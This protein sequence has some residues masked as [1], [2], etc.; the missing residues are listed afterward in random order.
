MHVVV[1]GPG[2]R[3]EWAVVVLGRLAAV[4][5]R[6]RPL[7][8]SECT[9][10]ALEALPEDEIETLL[11]VD[12]LPSVIEPIASVADGV[13]IGDAIRPHAMRLVL[14]FELAKKAKR[15]VALSAATPPEE[16]LATLTEM[17]G[18]PAGTASGDLPSFPSL[19]FD[20][21]PADSPERRAAM[22]YLQALDAARA[23]SVG[24]EMVW[25]R[26]LFLAG[27]L[28]GTIL[29]ATVEIA[30]RPRILAY[31]PYLPLP[32]GNWSATAFLGFSREAVRLPFIVE[33]DTGG[34][35]T[36]GFFEVDRGGIFS[37]DLDFEITQPLDLV[38]SRLIS[39]ES[40][41]EG[42]VSL[43]ELTLRRATQ[44]GGDS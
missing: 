10:A 20:P 14:A 24:P 5:G 43:I 26:E 33:I 21:D 22:T 44:P 27:D 15:T 7:I 18:G 17:V 39:Q 11:L 38:E 28:P 1:P 12:H 40:S 31:G 23:K 4:A 37:L 6:E 19:S 25:P 16:W 8:I 29:P 41:L 13:A 35:V 34:N 36:R 2:P 9:V 32:T 42:Q 3:A 30:G